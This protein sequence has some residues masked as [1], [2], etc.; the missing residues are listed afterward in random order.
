MK[1]HDVFAGFEWENGDVPA[2]IPK[3]LWDSMLDLDES[4]ITL[5]SAVCGDY[6]GDD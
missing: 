3:R 2:I 6:P 5:A 4:V 1:T